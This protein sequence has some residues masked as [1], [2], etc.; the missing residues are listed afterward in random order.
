MRRYVSYQHFFP[1]LFPP[2]CVGPGTISRHIPVSFGHL[3]GHGP[4]IAR[5]AGR[6]IR[7]PGSLSH[8]GPPGEGVRTRVRSLV[9]RYKPGRSGAP[10]AAMPRGQPGAVA[11]RRI[12]RIHSE[13]RLW[14]L[15]RR[16]GSAAGPSAARSMLPPPPL[17]SLTLI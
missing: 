7:C 9:R 5:L 11:G 3:V 8:C 12:R 16:V 6:S 10:G 17:Y 2:C 15:Y 1:S 13:R 14:L 4:Y